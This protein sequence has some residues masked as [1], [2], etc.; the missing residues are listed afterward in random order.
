MNFDKENENNAWCPGCG[1]FPIL[2]ALKTALTELNFSNQEVVLV[3]GIGQA[4]KMPQY[5]AANYFNGLH[6]RAIPPARGIKLANNDLKVIVTSGDGD[7]YGEG[8]NHFLSAI[9]E[10]SDITVLV[11]N[12]M[13]YGL[14]KGQASP[15]AQVGYVTK[16]QPHGKTSEPFNPIAVAIAE[17][18]SFVAR[19]LC[20]DVEKTKDIIIKA[21]QHKGFS[22]VDIL[23]AC[24]TFNKVN[25]YMWFKENSYYLEPDYDT[26]NRVEAFKK[27]LEEKFALGVIYERD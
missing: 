5:I 21:I 22:L 24:V 9:R 15:T 8:G 20:Q 16:M 14:T 19:A 12:N 4:G 23:Q 11:S 2:W 17:N 10:N 3:S 13:V 1:N 7:V 26:K 6:G 27:S 18:A 25:T